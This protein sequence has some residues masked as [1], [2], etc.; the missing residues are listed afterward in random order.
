MPAVPLPEPDREPWGEWIAVPM[1][2]WP[3]WWPSFGNATPSAG[4]LVTAI[5]T[6]DGVIAKA[7]VDLQAIVDEVLGMG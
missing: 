4:D 7:Y 5:G 1:T 2:G 6:G 3:T